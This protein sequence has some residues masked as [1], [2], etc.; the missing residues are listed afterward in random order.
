MKRRTKDVFQIK[1][2]NIKNNKKHAEI[3]WNLSWHNFCFINSQRE[4]AKENYKP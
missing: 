4:K 2:F 3:R 1:R